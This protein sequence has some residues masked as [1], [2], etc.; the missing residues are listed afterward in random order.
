MNTWSIN[1]KI[2]ALWETERRN[3]DSI[4]LGFFEKIPQFFTPELNDTKKTIL[5]VGINP[6]F[7][8]ANFRRLTKKIKDKNKKLCKSLRLR[9]YKDTE[10]FYKWPDKKIT[11]NYLSQL[12]EIDR[13]FE[14][15]TYSSKAKKIADF[16]SLNVFATDLFLMRGTSQKEIEKIIFAGKRENK[17]LTPFAEKQIEIFFDI[18]Q[19]IQPRIILVANAS[20]SKIIK[21]YLG[22][23]RDVA[24]NDDLGTY[25]IKIMRKGRG[26]PIFFSGMLSGQRALDNYSFQRLAWQIKRCIN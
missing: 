25:A 19:A 7:S 13:G 11:E 15:F 14:E 17:T 23:N 3:K 8:H 5:Y 26:V 12:K 4:K 10:R 16:C 18:V 20:A 6:S 1:Q 22:K 2:I 24:W 9:D 21:D